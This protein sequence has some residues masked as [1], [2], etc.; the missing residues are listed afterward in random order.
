MKLSTN[1]FQRFLHKLGWHVA[2]SP[3]SRLKIFESGKDADGGWSSVALPANMDFVDSERLLDD[4]LESVASLLGTPK[5]ILALTIQRWDLD[6]IGTRFGS[7]SGSLTSIPLSLAT[8]V[9]DDLRSF[10]GYAAYTQ[11]SPAKFYSKAGKV[12]SDFASSCHFGHTFDG[13]FG[14]TIEC[15][16]SN[17][18]QLSFADE[19]VNPPFERL[20][21][22][23]IAEGYLQF[24]TAKENEDP[25][26][27]LNGYKTGMSANMLRALNDVYESLDAG[28]TIEY[29]IHWAH[30]LAPP[31]QLS[32]VQTLKFD[33]LAYELSRFAAAELEKED[34]QQ[35]TTVASYVV[36]LKSEMPL[37]EG[38]QD[39]FEHVIT[40]DW[41]KERGNFVRIRVALPA[42]EYKK[43]CDAHKNGKKVA[44]SGIPEKEGKFWI[45][46][47]P[48]EIRFVT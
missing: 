31:K 12:A 25:S 20:V 18:R 28:L 1:N 8:L 42:G 16:L 23:R 17:V 30:E 38:M 9:V 21:T 27:L 44:V 32:T 14:M 15:P 5:P 4:A 41:E 29:S 26:P 2:D 37:S 47:R 46:T 48:S 10:M 11:V 19:L 7:R 3:N 24:Q 40:L 13:S 33:G 43:A 6:V 34:E 45:L 36:S 39:E 22:A 35:P